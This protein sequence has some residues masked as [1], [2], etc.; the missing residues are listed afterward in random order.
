MPS[1]SDPWQGQGP[2]PAQPDQP[3]H[4]RR[5]PPP[6]YG[7]PSPFSV[8]AVKAAYTAA[9]PPKEV[10]QAFLALVAYLAL[11]LLSSLISLVFTV[12]ILP[13]LPGGT[14]VVASVVFLVVTAVV[15]GA[16]L[17]VMIHMRAGRSWAR[18]TVAALSGMALLLAV[19]NLASYLGGLATGSGTYLVIFLL[20]SVA[21]SAL[22]VAALVLMFRPR[23]SGY[24]G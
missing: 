2:P 24:F 21:Q 9:R 7:P 15:Y 5:P 22:L 17:F 16:A 12:A 20:I 19:L 13:D 1:P 18:I 6:G 8:A 4:P 3:G 10:H 23:A 14:A 11:G